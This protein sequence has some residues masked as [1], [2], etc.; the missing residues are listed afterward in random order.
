MCI[1]WFYTYKLSIL[2]LNT[3]FFI[4]VYQSIPEEYLAIC[5]TMIW[6]LPFMNDSRTSMAR[7]PLGL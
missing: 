2:S 7:T 1:Q 6:D 4:R 3:E 5:I